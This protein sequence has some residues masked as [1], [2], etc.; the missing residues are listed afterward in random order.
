[1]R[2]VT[3]S[4]LTLLA[5]PAAAPAAAPAAE[6]T[7][8]DPARWVRVRADE[9]EANR[10]ALRQAG[11]TVT[12]TDEADDLV[13]GANCVNVTAREVQCAI[14]EGDPRADVSLGDLDDA[15]TTSGAI[16]VKLDGEAGDD[17]LTSGDAADKLGGG[18]GNDRL[19]GG[20]GVDEYSGGEGDDTFAARDGLRE[21]IVCGGGHDVVVAD[22]EDEI[23]PDC[24]VVERPL[25][26]AGLDAVQP[27]ADDPAAPGAGTPPAPPLPVPGRSV[28]LDVKSGTVLARTPGT[29]AFVPLDPTRPLPVGTLVNARNGVATLT[30][31]ADLN[32]ATQTADFKGGTFRVAQTRGASMTT[33]LRLAGGD[34]S[35]CPR[36]T[37]AARGAVA[38]ASA[39]RRVVRK[40]WGSGKGRF[41][42][43]GRDSAATVRGT[44][45]TVEDRCDGTVT[46]VTRG[47]VAVKNL[48]TGRTKLVRAGQS[49]LV[50]RRAR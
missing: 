41:R 44:V 36:A 37:T 27:A 5:L 29:A 33:E 50:R 26:P 34:F 10:L 25:P 43:R 35:R 16:P 12:V 7:A 22:V 23:N 13:A 21:P 32:G 38:H 48:R 19:E 9:G 15:A 28:A 24:E 40:L 11:A 45:W 30:A 6:V 8:Q 49:L 20:A 14:T 31:A 1:M 3:A 4:F 18:D 2:L 39:R 42:T 17:S 47:V 46:R